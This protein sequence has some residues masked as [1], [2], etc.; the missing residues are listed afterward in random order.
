MEKYGFVYI[1]LDK[2]HKRYYIG[3][4]WGTVDDGYICS[5]SW[6]K[7]AYKLRPQDFKRRILKT[8]ILSKTET[9]NEEQK[10]ISFIKPHELKTRYYNLVKNVI[11]HW[12]G[13]PLIADKISKIISETNKGKNYS[14]KTQFKKGERFNPSTEF[15]KGQEPWNKGKKYNLN[16]LRCFF[17]TPWGKYPSIDEAIKNCPFKMTKTKLYDICKYR[18]EETIKRNTNTNFPVGYKYKEL[19]YGYKEL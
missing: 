7:R 8:N 12:S 4:H 2:K 14:P 17:L 19:G 16:V 13:N 10:W 11:H 15:K 3:S 18:N 6:M 9:Y 5:S 1:W